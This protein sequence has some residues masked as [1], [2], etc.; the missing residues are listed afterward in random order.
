MHSL[1]FLTRLQII[2]HNVTMISKTLSLYTLQHF[3]NISKSPQ[4]K[5]IKRLDHK[6][7]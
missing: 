5:M 2:Y 3:L 6:V 4:N 7:F 1:F